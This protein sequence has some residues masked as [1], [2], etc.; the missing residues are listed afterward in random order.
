MAGW[1]LCPGV[2]VVNGVL[3]ECFRFGTLKDMS[4]TR[5]VGE[6]EDAISVTR[7]SNGSNIIRAAE[8]AMEYASV[9]KRWQYSP[10][11]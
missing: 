1:V 7:V 2:Q 11:S 10:A 4:E 9:N 3:V 8:L 6:A 5:G